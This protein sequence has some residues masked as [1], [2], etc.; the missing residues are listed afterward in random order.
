MTI[1]MMMMTMQRLTRNICFY[2]HDALASLS[3][4]MHTFQ[5]WTQARRT[6]VFEHGQCWT[7]HQ[8][9]L[10]CY[11]YFLNPN[12]ERVW[13]A[14]ESLIVFLCI[15]GVVDHNSSLPPSRLPGWMDVML[16]LERYWM[17]KISSRR[18]KHKGPTLVHPRRR[19]PLSIRVNCK[20]TQVFRHDGGLSKL[21][22]SS[23]RLTLVGRKTASS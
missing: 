2:C 5:L 10:L 19:W 22:D 7:Q 9:S 1:M 21:R 11:V 3:P 14:H 23:S 12:V 13:R 18:L 17:E 8:V 16:C 15:C 4:I 6:H 20:N